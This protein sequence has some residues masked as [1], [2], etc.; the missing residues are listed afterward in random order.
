MTPMVGNKRIC[1]YCAMRAA[2]HALE[3]CVNKESEEAWHILMGTIY[4]I[5]D[6][7]ETIQEISAKHRQ[8]QDGFRS[9]LVFLMRMCPDSQP[10]WTD[11][12]QNVDNP[13]DV[14]F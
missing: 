4:H 8:L 5:L 6:R 9:H 7:A 2:G 10:N 14:P 1:V 3:D 13:D 11:S 12:E